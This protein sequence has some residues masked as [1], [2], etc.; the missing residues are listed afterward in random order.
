MF[1]ELTPLIVSPDCMTY[2]CQEECCS[3]G[4]DVWPQERAALLEKGLASVSDFDD[5]YTDDE[6]DWLFR[7]ELG[8]RGCIF[9]KPDR[10]CRLHETGLKPEVCI[11]VPRNSTEADEMASYG[12]MPCRADWHF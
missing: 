7:T 5:G 11:A 4:C 12:M 8:P 6:G 9:L 3:H 2:P 10:G 1:Q